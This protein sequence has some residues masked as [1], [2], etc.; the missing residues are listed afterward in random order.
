MNDALDL[1]VV[2]L[3]KGTKPGCINSSSTSPRCTCPIP[4]TE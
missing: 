1:E 2:E 3:E 4:V